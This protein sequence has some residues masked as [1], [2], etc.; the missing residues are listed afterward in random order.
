MKQAAHVLLIGLLLGEEVLQPSVAEL[1]TWP[2]RTKDTSL[3]GVVKESH[4]VHRH[5]PAPGEPNKGKQPQ[6][7]VK[8]GYR[9]V[10]DPDYDPGR[11]STRRPECGSGRNS[12]RDSYGKAKQEAGHKQKLPLSAP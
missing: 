1:I 3:A 7:Q 12:Q 6:S 4:E 9:R 5:M 2:D 11:Y 10:R 8:R